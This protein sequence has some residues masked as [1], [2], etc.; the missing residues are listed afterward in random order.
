MTSGAI[1]TEGCFAALRDWREGTICEDW[2]E[3]EQVHPDLSDC[4]VQ[5]YLDEIYRLRVA[6]EFERAAR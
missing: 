4:E 5:A 1:F 6:A 3:V 2:Q